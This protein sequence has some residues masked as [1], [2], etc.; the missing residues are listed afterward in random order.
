MENAVHEIA[1]KMSPDHRTATEAYLAGDRDIAT[2]HAARQEI[3]RYTD[4]I[5]GRNR[6][7]KPGDIRATIVK[8][9]QAAYD[10]IASELEKQGEL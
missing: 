6:G 4:K 7:A 10:V 1:Q 3:A 8:T 5:R 2:L 9:G